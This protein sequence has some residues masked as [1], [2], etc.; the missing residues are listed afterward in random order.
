MEGDLHSAGE[1]RA[2]PGSDVICRTF[3]GENDPVALPDTGSSETAGYFF[4]VSY[5][6][7][8]GKTSSFTD[9]GRS[10]AFPV[11]LHNL[12]NCLKTTQTAVIHQKPP[13]KENTESVSVFHSVRNHY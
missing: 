1:E 8:I 9:Q 12:R 7:L 5:Q 13:K 3:D 2:E 6:I 10:H 11:L 4:C